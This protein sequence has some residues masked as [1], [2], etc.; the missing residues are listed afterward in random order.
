M[1]EK[2]APVSRQ[3]S[4]LGFT[5][6]GEVALFRKAR[7]Q[8][9][10]IPA[11]VSKPTDQDH[12]VVRHVL[13]TGNPGSRTHASCKTGTP[14]LPSLSLEEAA[15]EDLL[16]GGTPQRGKHS[17][18]LS[19]Q[20]LLAAGAVNHT[21][22]STGVVAPWVLAGGDPVSLRRPPPVSRRNLGPV[23]HLSKRVFEAISLSPLDH[24]DRGELLAVRR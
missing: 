22:G 4:R 14:G 20:T 15:E 6:P 23:Q 19:C 8:S 10:D 9:D 12:A 16:S 13:Q 17:L 7:N 21:E 1:E 18:P 3:V 2:I 5:Q 24:V 11:H